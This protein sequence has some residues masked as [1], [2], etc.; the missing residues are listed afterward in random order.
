MLLEIAI[1]CMPENDISKLG[2]RGFTKK[3]MSLGL[4]GAALAGISKSAIAEADIDLRDEK[5]VLHGW[6]HQ[7]HEEVKNGENPPRRKA[8][9]Y[10]VP[11]DKW[12][13]VESARDAAS[14]L[15]ERLREHGVSVG[16]GSTVRGHQNQLAVVVR[17]ATGESPHGSFEPEVE[18]ETL[19][20]Q[21]PAS[22]SGIAGRGTDSSR[23]VED[24]PVVIR[25]EEPSLHA[26]YDCSYRPVPAGCAWRTEAGNA[27]T[28]G[29]PVYDQKHGVNALVSAAHCFLS[30]DA[31]KCRQNN[32]SLTDEIGERD[33]IRVEFD[34]PPEL[35]DA[36]VINLDSSIDISYRTASS[37]CD[38]TTRRSFS[39]AV[40]NQHLHYM[41]QNDYS[42]TKQ[43]ITTGIKSGTVEYVDDT[44]FKTDVDSKDGDSGGP[45]WDNQYDG[46]WRRLLAGIHRGGDTYAH[47]TQM[48]EIEDRFD[49]VV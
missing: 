13:T 38:E 35:F 47:A 26:S 49:V 31:T 17:Y 8:L 45:Y 6:V 19:R 10:G 44:M 3:M 46:S 1:S 25:K 12:A 16:V 28:M 34:H 30:Y 42:L 39:G 2:R 48:V 14:T 27:C 11:H 37:N 18:F 7:N 20:D 21:I 33:D 43:G 15:R 24:I 32:N 5:P 23:L 9:Y 22:V 4:T 41:N 40:S 29:A 36:A